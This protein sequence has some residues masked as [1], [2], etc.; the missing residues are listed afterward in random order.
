MAH[1]LSGWAVTILGTDI[2]RHSLARA[3][4]G[5]FEEWALRSTPDDVKEACFTKEGRLWSLAPEYKTGVSFQYHN[6]VEHAFPSLV[7]NLFAFDL[8][9]CRNVMIYFATDLMRR[10]VGQFHGSLFPGAWLLVGPS[11]PNMTSFTSFRIV[12]APGLTLYLKPDE[13][14]PIQAENAPPIAVPP[15]PPAR[16][17][18]YASHA[19]VDDTPSTTSAALMLAGAR[20]HADRGAWQEAAKC[21]E[22]LLAKGH[23]N[24]SVHFYHGLV[25]EQMGRHAQAE[26]ALRRAIYLDRRY[27]LAHYYLGLFFQ[28]RGNSEQAA[29][30]FGNALDLLQIRRD[31]ESFADADGITARELKKLT[32]MHI[33]TLLERAS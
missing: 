33:E 29:R 21:C 17:V 8:I 13:G 20:G 3:R 10:I 19:P 32:K 9:V 1:Q 16:P 6:L 2:N 4:E 31:A 7:N 18:L 25:L 24:P 23:L 12:N 26:R 15:N 27:V 22:Q 30:S 5:K 14:R 28:A 11:E